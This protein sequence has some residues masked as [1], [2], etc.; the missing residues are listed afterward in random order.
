MF[1]EFV[2]KMLFCGQI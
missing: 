1:V 2:C